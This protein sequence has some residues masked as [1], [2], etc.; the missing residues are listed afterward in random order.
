M[1]IGDKYKLEADSLN[2]ILYK[3][4]TTKQLQEE[5]LLELANE[6]EPD[7][8]GKPENIVDTAEPDIKWKLLG[9][10]GTV[11]GVLNY[12]INNEIV[13]GINL[14]SLEKIVAGQREL[15]LL[16][17]SLDFRAITLESL[18]AKEEL[19]TLTVDFPANPPTKRVSDCIEDS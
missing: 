10:F 18:K 2:L 1:L 12:I 13:E 8:E 5:A 11:E 19:P 7:E 9:Y 15:A 17:I 4:V 3:K 16:I 14:S 6:E